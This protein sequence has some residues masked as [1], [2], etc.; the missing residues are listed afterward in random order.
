MSRAEL[1]AALG[2]DLAVI[3]ELTDDE[4]AEL[5][6]LYAAAREDAMADLVASLDESL[7]LV[8]RLVRGPVRAI[9]F[10]RGAR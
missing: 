1:K 4:A 9:L 7:T 8:P 6:E 10:P 2:G 5:L 3:D